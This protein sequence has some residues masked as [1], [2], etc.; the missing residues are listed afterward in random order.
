[1][2]KP[3]MPRGVVGS[4]NVG[5]GSYATLYSLSVLAHLERKQP[6]ILFNIID[7]DKYALI[8]LTKLG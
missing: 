2:H 5:A 4:A 6:A 7:I 3:P 1:M 8:K